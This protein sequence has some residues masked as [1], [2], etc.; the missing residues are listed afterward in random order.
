MI[1][2]ES[3]MRQEL[4]YGE[5]RSPLTSD[6]VVAESVRTSE[7][8]LFGEHVYWIE[9]RPQEEGRNA[10]VRCKVNDPE[11]MTETV[12]PAGYNA[13]TRVHEYGGGSFV[14]T[15]EEE[16]FF[17]NFEDQ[18]LYKLRIG[19]SP[20]VKVLVGQEQFGGGELRFG[21]F[22]YDA[23]RSCVYCVGEL[24]AAPVDG[25]PGKEHP[26][27]QNALYRVD[28][29]TGEC[30]KVVEGAD[31]YSSPRVSRDGS[32]LAWLSWQHPQMPWQ[33]TV[34]WV[35]SVHALT[36]KIQNAQ[37]VAGGPS[38]SV[39]QPRWNTNGTLYFVSD[40]SGW[41]N[42]YKYSWQ[43][44]I[45]TVWQHD[46]DIGGPQWMLGSSEVVT[47]GEQSVVFASKQL[48]HVDME[49]VCRTLESGYD[50]IDSVSG[51]GDLV[52]F[53]G[54]S[55]KQAV[56][57]V[58][59][60]LPS[61]TKRIL[62][63][64][65]A[66]QLDPKYLSIPELIHF[67]TTNDQHAHALYF[68]PKNDDF[69]A[70]PGTLPPLLVCSHGGPTG[71]AAR[72]LKPLVQYYTSRGFA[73]VDVDY[74]GSSGYGRAYRDALN[75]QWGIADVDDCC[76][77]ALFLARCGKA[78]PDR[79]TI[80]GSSAGG[81][82]TLACLT[83][84]NVFKAGA[85]HYGIGNLETLVQHTHKFESKYTFSLVGPYP[86]QQD[87]YKQRSP[88]HYV[89]RLSCPVIFFQ[90][91]QD[92]VVPPEQAQDMVNALDKKRLPVAYISFEKEQHG[93][94]MAHNIKRAIEAQYYFFCKVLGITPPQGIEPVPIKNME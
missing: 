70:P 57:V 3:E 48:R 64:E 89:D 74:R 10:I 85:S 9:S 1:R 68:A 93:F 31:F 12:L 18:Q 82:T 52:V 50:D 27:A 60:H 59:L 28:L 21:D 42:L 22:T 69:T 39:M 5:W 29:N 11:N 33:G 75:G 54:A 44:I 62:T 79:L 49:G 81:Y 32:K 73:V 86:D 47:L 61:G 15:S 30:A 65:S 92:L 71:S 8:T 56:E 40:A 78:D 76:N 17:V 26:E 13:R 6:D 4:P 46:A 34:L 84:R 53:R 45:E 35:A 41:W 38:E 55:F 37:R 24:H 51:E 23:G 43:G 91:L 25:E 72:L 58:L 88:I 87:V 36:G 19:E 67:P 77:A 63:R 94:R 7:L 20:S 90:G 66:A 83:F 80:C 2:S 14:V 16:L